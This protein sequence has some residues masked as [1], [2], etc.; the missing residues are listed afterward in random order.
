[1]VFGYLFKICQ[2]VS[3]LKQLKNPYL[4]FWNDSVTVTALNKETEVDCE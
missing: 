4:L 2:R 3:Y 1:M